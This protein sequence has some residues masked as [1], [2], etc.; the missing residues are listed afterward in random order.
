MDTIKGAEIVN[1]VTLWNPSDSKNQLPPFPGIVVEF[2]DGKKRSIREQF[3]VDYIESDN[4]DVYVVYWGNFGAYACRD[5][6]L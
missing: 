5:H 6:H 1:S 4:R 3:Y 2:R